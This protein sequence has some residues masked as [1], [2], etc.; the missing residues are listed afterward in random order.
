M[1]VEKIMIWGN[2]YHTILTRA[3][4][5]EIRK[6][7]DEDPTDVIWL[8]QHDNDPK[9][10]AKKNKRYLESKEREGKLNSHVLL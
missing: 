7:T 2:Q 10:T 4:T 8:F 1:E 9:H 5:P 6:L 3:V